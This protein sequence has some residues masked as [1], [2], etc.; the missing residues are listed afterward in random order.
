[1]VVDRRV[2]RLLWVDQVSSSG[3]PA[4]FRFCWSFLSQCRTFGH[5]LF[6]PCTRCSLLWAGPFSIWKSLWL[7]LSNHFSSERPTTNQ[8]NDASSLSRGRDWGKEKHWTRFSGIISPMPSLNAFG[9]TKSEM[10]SCHWFQMSDQIILFLII[11]KV[12]AFAALSCY[13]C[14]TFK[15]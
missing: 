6:W 7:P 13:K 11:C 14:L 5:F 15:I 2:D 12:L 8:N 4:E 3:K 10:K 1:M 9:E